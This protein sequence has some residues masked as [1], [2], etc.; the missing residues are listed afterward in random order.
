MTWQHTSHQ[1]DWPSFQCLAHQG[2]V[3]IG[4]NPLCQRPCLRPRNP[5]DIDQQTDQLGNRQNGMRIVEMD[6][7]LLCQIIETRIVELMPTDQI[8]KT[9]RHE[10]IF[11]HQTQLAPQ[12]CGIVRIQHP[13]DI[14]RHVFRFDGTGIIA[15][16]ESGQI[17][18]RSRLGRP[19][20][21]CR[22]T[23][24][25]VPRDDRIIGHCQHTV[26]I[27]PACPAT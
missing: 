3:G 17:D 12:W 20:T 22:R 25:A 9:C 16:V 10:K 8:L 18:F 4:E 5:L 2:V 6:R 11:L 23:F 24:G 7:N 26:R 1:I 14:F 15:L 27:D 19:Q 21:Q 13:C